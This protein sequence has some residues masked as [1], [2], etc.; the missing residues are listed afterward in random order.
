MPAFNHFRLGVMAVLLTATTLASADAQDRFAAARSKMVRE[1]LQ[2][3][4]IDNEA[5]LES[6]RQTPRHEFVPLNLRDDA[7]LDT[8]LPIG[9]GQTISPP[10]IVAF[11]TQV[12]DPKPSD[13]VL[14]IGTGSG[15]Q[16]AV[17]SPLVAEVYTIEIVPKLGRTAAQALQRQGY[18]NV[19][20]KVGDGFLGWP[21]KA[22]FD[23]IIVTCSPENV[24]RPLV[25]QLKEGGRMVI[26]IGERFQQT[27]VLLR[28]ENG[29]LVQ[30]AL[31]PTLFVPMT[32]QAEELRQVQPDG[33]KPEIVNGSFEVAA[34]PSD[35]E[36]AVLDAWHYLRHGEVIEDRLA[37]H[38]THFLRFRNDVPGRLART[39]QGFAV[40]GRSVRRL[41]VSASVRTKDVH[42]GRRPDQ[43]GYVHVTFFDED[44]RIIGEDWLGPFFGTFDWDQK[45][46][47]LPV[48]R[49][50]R[51]AI[52][53]IGLLGGVG[54]LD[55]DNVRIQAA[56]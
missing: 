46:G 16:A 17:L 1:S 42:A 31:R 6:M 20:T 14:E 29:K 15:Y 39:V 40:D 45:R 35:D 51:S 47:L 8:A 22:P 48:P 28:K 33:T 25:E 50:A 56:P 18:R 34:K 54:E 27:M 26:P 49:Q 38:E 11:M 41:A 55:I 21:E 23:K 52:A 2:S 9:E 30:E 53:M 13:R 19:T 32:G 4:G 5:V 44:Q 3:A 12:L 37:P 36:T 7:Y 10:F 24:P 43:L